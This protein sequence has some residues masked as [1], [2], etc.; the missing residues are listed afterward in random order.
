[1]TNSVKT[2][3][4]GKIKFFLEV[5]TTIKRTGDKNNPIDIKLNLNPDNNLIGINE[6]L[7][8]QEDLI[9]VF[10]RIANLLGKIGTRTEDYSTVLEINRK[11][12]KEA[13]FKEI[14]DDNFKPPFEKID[15]IIY[16]HESPGEASVSYAR[17]Y[18]GD[19]KPEL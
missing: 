17:S 12:A 11:M 8:T 19:K 1:M 2:L 9:I 18:N 7:S 14:Y 6:S 3:K 15:R 13:E 16:R 5:T 10:K 4:D